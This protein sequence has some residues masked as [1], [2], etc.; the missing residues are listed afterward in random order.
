M[1]DKMQLDLT[2][3][4]FTDELHTDVGSAAFRLTHD[5]FTQEDLVIRTA[6]GGGGTLLAEGTD[7]QLSEQDTYYSGESGKTVYTEI[8]I[9]NATYQT[10]DLYFSGEYIGDYV[11]AEDANRPRLKGY[12][13]GLELANNAVDANNDIDIAAGECVD[14]EGDWW[15]ELSATLTK[16]LDASWA[17]GDDA[18]GLFSGSKAADT[19]Y[20]V[21]LIRQDVA[22][23]IDAG[24][25]TDPDAA[26]IPS[27]WTA[28]RRLGAVITDGS[29]NI[30]SFYQDGDVFRFSQ[31]IEDRSA[32]AA[33]NTNRNLFV[34]TAP[35]NTRVLLVL[36]YASASDGQ[37][38]WIDSV[39]RTD[40]A[41]SSSNYNMRI[42][43]P[44]QNVAHVVP[45]EIELDSSSQFAIR[46]NTTNMSYGWITEGWIDRR[47]RLAA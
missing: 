33:S 34:V 13:Y 47:G 28:Y 26:N 43:T 5:M 6:S 36:H 16:Q 3:A 25:D 14:S 8:Q 23:T 46:V 29:S 44:S 35:P 39:N 41:A 22:G 15:M 24:F 38:G 20:H 12:L 18:G 31:P 10:G 11:E 37:Y 19:T 32:A 9:I 30:L 45:F 27:G 42:T 17:E 40:A 2:G 21:F 1:P 7:Y 4:A